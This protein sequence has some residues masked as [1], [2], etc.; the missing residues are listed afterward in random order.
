[1]REQSISDLRRGMGEMA[2]ARYKDAS[3]SFAKAVIKNSKDPMTH[4][5]FGASLYW[6]GKVDEAMVEYH[7]ALRL[8]PNN[9]MAYQ[10]LG[11]AYGWK[12]DLSLAQENFLKANALDPNKADTHMNLGSTYTVQKNFDKALDHFRKAVE[13]APRH[14]L[15]QYQLGTLYEAMGRDEQAE[16]CFKKA[17]RFYGRYEDAMLALAALY[18]KMDNDK[19]ALKYY[20]KAVKIKPGDFVARLR[21]GVLL[22]KHGD[23]ETTREVLNE[24]FSIVQFKQDG[25]ALNAVYRAQGQDVKP[26]QEQ[27]AKFKNGL[28][29]VPSTKDIDVEVAL[30]FVPKAQPEPD[31]KA[32]HT[33][34]EK[35]Y[36]SFRGAPSANAE[37]LTPMSFKRN[38]VLPSADEENRARQIDEFITGVGQAVERGTEKYTV[39]MS[40][41][42]RTMDFNSPAALTQYQD[43]APRAVYDP[44]IVGNDMGLWVM[45]RT[46]LKF[47]DEIYSELQENAEKEGAPVEYLLL[48]GLA[49]L[50]T[51]DSTEAEGF[52]VRSKTRNIVD[53]LPLMGL[54]TS[55]VIGGKDALAKEY[56]EQALMLNPDNKVAKKNLRVFQE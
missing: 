27:I 4:L 39:S 28:L 40:L 15:Y 35:A 56:Y 9:P 47:V 24:A 30:D 5:L 44:R 1:M 22:M 12:G 23:I 46:W 21:Y 42:G 32:Q 54:G 48:M 29:Q 14:P 2:F 55:A 7:E 36:Q 45:G 26:F 8:E 31:P 6:L 3:N 11:I 13:L 18:E 41:Q 16:A 10:L 25:L 51:G 17:L 52:F 20:K 37:A 34:F 38:F 50:V 19:E 53:D 33:L 43:R 49:N